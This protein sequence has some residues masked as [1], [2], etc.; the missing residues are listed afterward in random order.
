MWLK[1]F[2]VFAQNFQQIEGPVWSL[3]LDMM[4]LM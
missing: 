2:K 1:I 4:V 3:M